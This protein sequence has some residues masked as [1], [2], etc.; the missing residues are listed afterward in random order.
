M[1]GESARQDVIVNNMA[2]ADTPGYK[3]QFPLARTLAQAAVGAVDGEEAAGGQGVIGT[4]GFG[5][6]MGQAVTSFRQAGLRSTGNE[7]D[8]ALDGPGFFALD[9]NGTTMYTR[10]GSFRVDREGYL[11]NADGYRILGESGP[12]A[13]GNGQVSFGE[14]GT[15]LV[16]G[17]VAGRLKVV[18]FD[19]KGSLRRMGDNLFAAE[20]EGRPAKAFVRSGFLEMADVQPV[21]EMVELISV[22]R[23][24]E[25]NQRLIRAQDEVLGKAVTEIGRI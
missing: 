15:V 13:I 19:D 11:V 5:A 21:K 22:M 23:A 9:V 1:L 3:R 14:D 12:L 10:D 20:G 4:V 2:N 24:Y 8:L 18:D 6:V 17:K 25:A 7:M 16:D